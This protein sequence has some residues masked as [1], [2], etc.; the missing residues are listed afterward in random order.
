[1]LTIISYIEIKQFINHVSVHRQ[2]RKFVFAIEPRYLKFEWKFIDEK[3]EDQW[4]PYPRMLKTM[5]APT[6]VLTEHGL[7]D[8]RSDFESNSMLTRELLLRLLVLKLAYLCRCD[9]EEVRTS[10]FNDILKK[11]NLLQH[12]KALTI[13]SNLFLFSQGEA[14][15][16]SYVS[17]EAKYES[18]KMSWAIKLRVNKLKLQEL[19]RGLGVAEKT[20]IVRKSM[21]LAGKHKS[22]SG[23]LPR[24]GS[25]QPLSQQ[26]NATDVI[27]ID[28]DDE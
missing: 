19:Q 25:L 1:M 14:Q 24:A 10:S 12:T 6:M 23:S 28:D 26:P 4:K 5:F 17:R 9:S 7:I 8:L 13:Y 18:L 16:K 2:V 21:P 20:K 22:G 15:V 27:E 3:D 11:V